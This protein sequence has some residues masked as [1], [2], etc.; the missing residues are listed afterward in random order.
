MDSLRAVADATAFEATKRHG[1]NW[2]CPQAD[3]LPCPVT[4]AWAEHDRLLLRGPQA[5]RARRRLPS[6]R[7]LVL[8]DCGHLPSWD[9]PAQTAAVIREAATARRG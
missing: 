1:L 4:V 5:P 8:H 9:D 3:P 7:H 2:R 6:A